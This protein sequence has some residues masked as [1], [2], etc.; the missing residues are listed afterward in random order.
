MSEDDLA[1]FLE[2]PVLVHGLDGPVEL[3]TEGLGEEALNWDVELLGEDDGQTRI[4]I[5]LE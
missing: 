4:D 1:P 2:L 3:L 5:V